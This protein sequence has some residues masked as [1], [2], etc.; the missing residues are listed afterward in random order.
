MVAD[1]VKAYK[2]GFID[3]GYAENQIQPLVL[4][5]SEVRALL[6]EFAPFYMEKH[7]VNRMLGLDD[8]HLTK[9]INTGGLKAFN[10]LIRTTG[11]G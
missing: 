2:Q 5:L 7:D 4:P 8:I 9:H 10:V 3:Q 11:N 6:R 1:K